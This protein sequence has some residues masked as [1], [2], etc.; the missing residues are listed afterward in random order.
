[1]EDE[2]RGTTQTYVHS[3]K[4]WAISKNS[5]THM[6]EAWKVLN[7]NSILQTTRREHRQQ[8]WTI[9]NI[10]KCMM[11]VFSSK[12]PL[13]FWETFFCITNSTYHTILHK[14]CILTTANAIRKPLSHLRCPFCITLN[15]R[16][17]IHNCWTLFIAGK[18][19]HL[20]AA[21]SSENCNVHPLST[22]STQYRQFVKP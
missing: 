12:I 21:V 16:L 15:I 19:K 10:F 6:V 4:W 2:S 20:I 22:V 1:M 17:L 11:K 7:Q 13:S 14:F 3:K 5:H 18:N 9:H 8:R